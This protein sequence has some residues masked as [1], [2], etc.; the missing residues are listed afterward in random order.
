M[1]V[2]QRVNVLFNIENCPKNASMFKP[3]LL[4]AVQCTWPAQ[5]RSFSGSGTERWK[6][7]WIFM[8]NIWRFSWNI[9]KR[10][11]EFR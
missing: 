7:G 2:Y 4:P 6:G 11:L 1:L 10:R 3:R 5:M 8:G 9:L